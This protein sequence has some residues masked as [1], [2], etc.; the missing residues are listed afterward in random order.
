M[1]A[2]RHP[3]TLIVSWH[4]PPANRASAGVLG[5]LFRTSPLGFFRVITRSFDE[6]ATVDR[7]P[8]PDDL[9]CRVPPT[10]V[11]ATPDNKYRSAI[12][13]TLG[14]IKTICAIVRAALA[15]GRGWPASQV[16]AVYPHRCGMLSGW[17]VAQRLHVPLIL[18][19]HDLCAEAQTI[20][21]PL[22]RWLWRIV[23]RVCLKRAD[24]VI[25]PTDEFAA[26]YQ[27]RGV[28]ATWVLPHCAGG[29][30]LVSD[31]PRPREK[32][33]L[34]YSGLVYEPHED[35][36]RAFV[37]A[38]RQLRDVAVTFHSNPEACGGL[39]GEA[40]AR[41]VSF[42][43]ATAAL[44]SADVLV[45][46]LGTNTPCPEEVFGCFPSKLIEYLSAGRAILAIV[47]S[48]CFVD[49]FISNTG[50]GVVASEHDPRTIQTA[51]DRLRDPAIRA[52]MALAATRAA[53]AFRSEHWMPRLT[54]RLRNVGPTTTG[55][56]TT[57]IA[58][59]PPA[60]ATHAL[61]GTD[62]R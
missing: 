24:L 38:T 5:A 31:P 13:A 56:R 33:H 17:W 51:I 16:L 4:W 11:P 59:T 53:Q 52:K 28:K 60:I 37:A 39:L 58:I 6:S 29:M 48:G 15:V 62:R 2:N 26:H 8:A 45:V 32:L 40:G 7:R 30:T 25:V 19:M 43:E 42:D 23:D 57:S 9:D 1:S 10:R 47:P 20:R 35:A 18:Y 22:R 21:N 50:C 36:A 54:Q 12:V 34:L 46:L 55:V 41:W 49:R 14:T 27:R 3:R 44:A 61:P